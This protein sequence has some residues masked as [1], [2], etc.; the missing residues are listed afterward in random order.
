[1]SAK[2]SR[3]KR[4]SQMSHLNP[5]NALKTFD[6]RQEAAANPFGALLSNILGRVDELTH[7]YTNLGKAGNEHFTDI[8]IARLMTN[9]PFMEKLASYVV[10]AGIATKQRADALHIALDQRKNAPMADELPFAKL[11]YLPPEPG[12]IVSQGEDGAVMSNVTSEIHST[13]GFKPFD[14]ADAAVEVY[15][16]DAVTEEGVQ[17]KEVSRIYFTGNDGKLAELNPE[18][19]HGAH[20]FSALNGNLKT[21]ITT[22]AQKRENFV[23]GSLAWVTMNKTIYGAPETPD[24]VEAEVEQTQEVT[25]E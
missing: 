8:I 24:N 19:E 6:P 25:D 16:K 7:A 4:K 2:K 5:A 1:M 18:S 11:N 15:F 3:A 12:T 22:N 17:I 20:L 10:Q 23:S 13:V 21:L 9:E 14:T